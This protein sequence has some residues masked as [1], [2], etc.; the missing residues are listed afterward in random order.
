MMVTPAKKKAIS[1]SKV[2]LIVS[3]SSQGDGCEELSDPR[4]VSW[5]SGMGGTRR[6]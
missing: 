3:S 5:L 6:A 4:I 1:T 2:P